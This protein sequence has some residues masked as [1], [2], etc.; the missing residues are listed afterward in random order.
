MKTACLDGTCL[1]LKKVLFVPKLVK[2]LLSVRA[3]T[4]VGA[5]VRFIR[6]KCIVVKDKRFIEIGT[7]ENGSLYKFNTCVAYIPSAAISLHLVCS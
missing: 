6:D 5:E 7:S 1:A 2:N 3:M 4:R